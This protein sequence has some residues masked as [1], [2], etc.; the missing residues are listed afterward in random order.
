MDGW[1]DRWLAGWI[2]LLH[3]CYVDIRTTQCL[4]LPSPGSDEE[5]SGNNTLLHQQQLHL[6]MV[7]YSEM[8]MCSGE[9]FL[10]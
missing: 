3:S 4:W 5:G 6:T 2:Y 7:Q 9:S 8:C 10:C 1:A